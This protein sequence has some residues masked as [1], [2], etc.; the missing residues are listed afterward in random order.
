MF[1]EWNKKKNPTLTY[2]ARWIRRNREKSTLN[3]TKN[4][5]ITQQQRKRA[6]SQAAT[7]LQNDKRL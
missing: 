3:G 6:G 5:E 1:I 4:N 7:A 2:T